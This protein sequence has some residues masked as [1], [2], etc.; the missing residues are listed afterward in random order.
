[1]FLDVAC[2]HQ[3]WPPKLLVALRRCDAPFNTDVR[4]CGSH[5]TICLLVTPEC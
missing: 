4:V 2:H 1:M 3:E 5:Q